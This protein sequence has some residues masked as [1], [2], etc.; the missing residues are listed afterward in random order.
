MLC[1]ASPMSEY[2]Q[3][4]S[5]F[6][7]RGSK[8]ESLN[9]RLKVQMPRIT[10]VGIGPGP[11]S[12]LTKEAEAEL[13]RA[14]KIFFRL[15]SHPVYDWLRALGKQLISFDLLYTTNWPNPEAIYEFMVSA[16]LKEASLRGEVI[17]AVPGS[18]AIL[19]DTT[20]LIRLWAPKNKSK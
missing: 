2:C 1:A 12:C 13:I 19:E 3:N 9:G 8:S 17:Y 14:D 4:P 15:G 10:V 18:P 7:K 5:S 20:N 16:I 6:S 11:I